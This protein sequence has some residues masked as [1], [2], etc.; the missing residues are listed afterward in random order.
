MTVSIKFKIVNKTPTDEGTVITWVVGFSD[1]KNTSTGTGTALITQSIRGL[2]EDEILQLAL[3][4]Q[5]GLELV[6]ELYNYHSANLKPCYELEFFDDWYEAYVFASNQ[7]GTPIDGKET[8]YENVSLGFGTYH[9]R[10]NHS[11]FNITEQCHWSHTFIY[12][13]DGGVHEVKED[14]SIGRTFHVKV[15]NGAVA[16]WY[17]RIKD[18]TK[19]WVAYDLATSQAMEYYIVD[20][21]SEEGTTIMQKFNSGTD[22]LATVTTHGQPGKLNLPEDFIQGLEQADFEHSS[23]IFGYATKSYGKIVEYTMLAY[24]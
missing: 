21:G 10:Y 8:A 12:E 20:L 16:E 23:C 15:R 22:E 14:A 4:S 7:L 5:G 3:N 11:I 9:T 2:L 6:D 19:E 1:G 13:I 24:R 18:G 17:E